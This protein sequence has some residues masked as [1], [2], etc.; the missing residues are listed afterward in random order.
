MVCPACGRPVALSR[1]QCLYCGALL[2][3]AARPGDSSGR[4]ETTTTGPE[5]SLV[6][7]DLA[8]ADPA[9]LARALGL[10]T[11]EA[12][13]RS[14]RGA[15]DLWR[16]LPREEA[17]A[18]VARL[19][20]HGVRALTVHE[21][22]VREAS[23]PSLASG[24]RLEGSTLSARTEGGPLRVEGKDVLLQ[25]MGEIARGYAPEA[26]V[27]RARTSTLDPGHRLHL[28]FVGSPRPLEIDPGS[29]DFGDAPLGRSSLLTLMEWVRAVAPSAPSDDGFRRQVPALA[30]SEGD[31]AGPAAAARALAT[32]GRTGVRGRDAPVV[33]DNLAQFRFYSSWRG[34][35]ERARAQDVRG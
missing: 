18:E 23:R 33:L 11:F 17:D 16:S 27:R 1:P 4:P 29:F 32:A 28:H 21:S 24:G 13:Q 30:P 31:L 7:L 22:G 26:K 35:A 12:I 34:A 14:R 15:F 20:T 2:P 8:G 19:S 6:I 10:T 5:R 25:V 3:S 9:A